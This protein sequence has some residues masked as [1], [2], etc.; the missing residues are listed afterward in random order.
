[1]KKFHIYPKKTYSHKNLIHFYKKTLSKITFSKKSVTPATDF[2]KHPP[3]LRQ[4]I[5]C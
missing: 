2:F 4:E 3:S 5:V 1:M